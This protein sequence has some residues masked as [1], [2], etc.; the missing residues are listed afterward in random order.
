MVDG[1]GRIP[2]ADR[3]NRLQGV[4]LPPALVKGHPHRQADG[5]IQKLRQLPQLLH[6]VRPTLCIAAGKI[7]V[8]IVL[9][10][11]PEIGKNVDGQRGIGIA[12]VHHILPDQHPQPVTMV[13]PAQRLH[14]D[15]LSQHIK[16]Q[17]FHFGDVMDHRFIGGSGVIAVAPVALI[18]KTV[19]EIGTAVQQQAGQSLLV[20]PDA[21][22]THPEVAF[23]PVAAWQD[24][25]NIVKERVL[26]APQPQRLRREGQGQFTGCIGLSRSHHFSLFLHGDPGIFGDIRRQRKMNGSGFRP[27]GDAQR[28]QV[29]FRDALHPNRL[30]DTGLRRVPYAAVF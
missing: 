16:A 28:A 22:G 5:I 27:R 21:E 3:L 12:A 2:S 25:G 20:P 26:R 17:P 9:D 1:P 15:V 6:I 10:P 24:D 8:V 11:Q 19:V 13:V 4:K 23:H 29:V 18:Q 30:P 7:A 14:L